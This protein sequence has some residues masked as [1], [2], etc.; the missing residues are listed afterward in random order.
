VSF[1]TCITLAAALSNAMDFRIVAPSLV[2]VI[3]ALEADCRILSYELEMSVIEITI[4]LGPR[5][6]F[7]RSPTAMA[8][9]NED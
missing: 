1:L 2:T 4:P 9:T 6:L 7:T 8:P 5:V 3:S